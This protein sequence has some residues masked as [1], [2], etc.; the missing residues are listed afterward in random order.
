MRW[1]R[2]PGPV[3]RASAPVRRGFTLLESL[4]ALVVIG[5]AA[6]VAME[7]LAGALR[8]ERQAG[9]HLEAV[10]LAEAA[11]DELALVPRDSLRGWAEP[12]TVAYPRPFDR[13]RSRVRLRQV[14]GSASLVQA[15]VTVE[16]KGGEYSL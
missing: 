12:R 16:W 9:R 15:N 11:M 14:P 6:T 5:L 1:S 10:A 8:G 2:T 4:V 7:A 13:Y 3:R